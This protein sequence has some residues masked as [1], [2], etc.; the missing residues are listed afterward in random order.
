MRTFS[1]QQFLVRA[2]AWR[3][4][5]ATVL[6]LGASGP[7]AL[8]IDPFFPTFGNNGY[9]VRHYDLTFD[10]D[11]ATHRVNAKA[12]L[13]I[14]AETALQ[15]FTL[16]LSGL[17]VTSVKVNDVAAKF[18]R[19]PGKL[20]ITPARPIAKG[21]VFG[22]A[23]AYRG[24]PKTI[25]D[26]TV[27]PPPPYP[28]LGWTNWQKVSY[29]VSEPVGAGTWYPV[30][31]EPTD[32]ASYKVTVTVDKPYKAVSNGALRAVVDLGGKRRFVWEQRQPMASYLAIVDVDRFEL[33]QRQASNGIV[34]RT[35]R[36]ADTPRDSLQ[37]L[38]RTPAMMAYFEKFVGSYP[39]DAYGA[40][41]VGDPDLYY[42]LETQA[43]STFQKDYVDEATVAH[44]LAH[45]WFGDAVTV[46]EWRDLWLA[47]GFATYLEFMWEYRA[48]RAALD[49][50]FNRLYAYVVRNKV[51]PAVVSVP[52]DIFADNT[53]YRGSLT[54]QAL[55]LEVG[56]KA[57]FATL[58]S[59]YLKYRYG[60]ATSAD[61]IDVAVKVSGE[62]SVRS[63]LHAWLYD[64][65]V[66][67][68]PGATA[69]AMAEAGAPPRLGIG[70][71]RH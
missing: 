19:P 22:V 49:D 54:L 27:Y 39:F 6:A 30:N 58:K 21:A 3:L 66:P 67:A 18:D 38:Y 70:V 1:V 9:D 24:V 4:A 26:P 46:A 62:P 31:D 55:R 28:Q 43:M 16:D 14:K 13:T 45:Q 42:A 10:V 56:D 34:I 7:P 12:V 65:E 51:G 53:Y 15:R 32:K 71:R 64:E 61:F 35:Y 2:R 40:V 44:E 68:L 69:T 47:E 57:F 5:A 8:A 36:T 63:L 59:F 37:A 33:D 11:G 48:S 29:V 23:I 60:N 25:D 41:L 17:D 52:Q 50:A 20:R